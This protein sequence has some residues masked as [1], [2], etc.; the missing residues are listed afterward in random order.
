MAQLFTAGQPAWTKTLAA[1]PASR[2][3][4]VTMVRSPISSF[5][6]SSTASRTSSSQTNFSGS[7][8]VAGAWGAE[9]P[10]V[11]RVLVPRCQASRRQELVDPAGQRVGRNRVR[12]RLG[13]RL[14]ERRR[15]GHLA[16]SGTARHRRHLRHLA[17][18]AG[19]NSYATRLMLS[20]C[21]GEML[22]EVM[23]P[24][25]PPQPS[26]I[27]GSSP[28]VRPIDPCVVGVLTQMR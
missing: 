2:A 20:R 17:P 24:P 10:Q 6:P 14:R 8:A 5:R 7:A 21:F 9:V 26:V 27:A 12:L 13:R 11:P 18:C 4:G 15:T 16:P 19:R 25:K 1:S 28:V 23:L 3:A 22:S